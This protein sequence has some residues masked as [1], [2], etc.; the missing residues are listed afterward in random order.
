MNIW[1]GIQMLFLKEAAKCGGAPT[2]TSLGFA[3]AFLLSV[4]LKNIISCESY[5]Q[6]Q[7]SFYLFILHWRA[8]LK[9]E[10]GYRQ[11]SRAK[12]ETSHILILF[13]AQVVVARAPAAVL[14]SRPSTSIVE[15]AR[16]FSIY[17]PTSSRM[18]LR[19]A[20]IPGSGSTAQQLFVLIP[21]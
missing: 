18:F 10:E 5:E 21:L 6:E 4:H 9:D 3:V 20:M 16:F 14:L 17:M 19:R 11:Y 12:N 13:L 1:V 7:P 8:T 2:Q 15:T